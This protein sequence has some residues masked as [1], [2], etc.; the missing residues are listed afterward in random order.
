MLTGASLDSHHNSWTF[1]AS[2]VSATVGI[3]EGS[4]TKLLVGSFALYTPQ[5][6]AQGIIKEGILNSEPGYQIS[7]SVG[8]HLPTNFP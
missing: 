2:L 5:W 6:S 4:T 8:I 1:F 7:G 3:R